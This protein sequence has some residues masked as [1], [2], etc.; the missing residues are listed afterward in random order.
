MYSAFRA[1]LFREGE[2]KRFAGSGFHDLARQLWY[3]TAGL[4]LLA[5]VVSAVSTGDTSP[6]E[7]A[8]N[9]AGFVFSIALI[10]LAYL[11]SLDLALDLTLQKKLFRRL[12]AVVHAALTPFNLVKVALVVPIYLA[13][14][15]GYEHLIGRPV[16][17]VC[18]FVF[19]WQW[20]VEAVVVSELYGRKLAL[21]FPLVVLLRLFT[22]AIMLFIS[23]ILWV[24]FLRLLGG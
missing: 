17:F 4:I 19:W 12:A 13:V 23:S 10:N 14:Y 15:H 1:S 9:S 18:I 20:L 6:A 11:L 3:Y 24:E 7:L 8:V 16:Y 5:V 22:F 21:V 2:V